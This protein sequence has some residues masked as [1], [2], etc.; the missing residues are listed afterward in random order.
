LMLLAT[1]SAV[2]SLPLYISSHLL[3]YCPSLRVQT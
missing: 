2:V 1:F 3:I